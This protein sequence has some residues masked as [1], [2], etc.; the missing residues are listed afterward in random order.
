LLPGPNALVFLLTFALLWGGCAYAGA[1]TIVNRR[2]AAAFVL[3]SGVLLAPAVWYLA[4]LGNFH[5]VSWDRPLN[6]GI[7]IFLGNSLN[8]VMQ[9][10]KEWRARAVWFWT[11]TGIAALAAITMFV[12]PPM[13]GVAVAVYLA[14]RPVMAALRRRSLGRRLYEFPR[15]HPALLIGAGGFVLA[16]GLVSETACLLSPAYRN[17]A[18]VPAGFILWGYF[19]IYRAGRTI[20]REGGIEWQGRM[21]DWGG[22][23]GYEWCDDLKGR[24]SLRLKCKRMIRE[25]VWI[26]AWPMGTVESVLVSHGV[27]PLYPPEGA[28]LPA[29]G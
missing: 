2:R 3:L 15:K 17:I 29:A 10:L 9:E 11:F 4:S 28:I 20:L 26:P 18:I 22:L 19:L 7:V 21:I 25:D 8:L 16:A 23:R 14:E 6:F 12:S 27:G 24:P 5:P 1:S 13:R